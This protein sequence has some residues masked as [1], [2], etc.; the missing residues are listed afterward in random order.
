MHLLGGMVAAL[1]INYALDL[2]QKNK[3]IV[4]SNLLLKWSMI[5][6]MVMAVAVLWEFYE[7]I[8]DYFYGTIHQPTLFDTIKDLF[9]GMLGAIITCLLFIRNKK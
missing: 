6:A 7:F 9:D 2:F 5:T 4:I 1:S 8:S 3:T